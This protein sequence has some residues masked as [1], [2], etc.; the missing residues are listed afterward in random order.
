M[1]AFWRQDWL[2]SMPTSPQIRIYE[3]LSVFE[4]YHN[5]PWLIL[6][7]KGYLGSFVDYFGY[8]YSLPESVRLG[9]FSEIQ[10]ANG[11]FFRVHETLCRLWLANGL[12]GVFGFIYISISC[13]KKPNMWSF[14]GLIWFVFYMDTTITLSCIGICALVLSKITDKKKET[15]YERKRN[16]CLPVKFNMGDYRDNFKY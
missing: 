14:M 9:A 15:I 11:T 12:V 2:Q 10:W 6:F 5:K 13:L 4:E 1:L 7:G 16:Q 3:F 8:F